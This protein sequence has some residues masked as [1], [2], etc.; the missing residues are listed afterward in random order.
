MQHLKEIQTLK[1]ETA[2]AIRNAISLT[3][4]ITGGP[5]LPMHRASTMEAYTIAVERAI[6]HMKA[7]LAEP[8]DLDQLARVASISRFHLVRVFDELTGTTPHHF[9]ACLRMQ[10]AKDLLLAP[11]AS[12]TEVCLEVGYTSLGTFSTTFST[13]VGFSPQEFRVMTKRLTV[14]QFA[15][16][17]RR[18]L[19]ADRR[20]CEP[21]IDG[22][23][24]GPP[25][26]RGFIFVGSFTHGVPQGAPLSGNVMLKPGAFC[27]KR[28]MIPEFHLLAVLIPFTAKWS[29]MAANLPVR[30]VAGL[31][32]QNQDPAKPLRPQLRLRP[33]RPTDPPIVLALPPL[34]R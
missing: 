18:F 21:R 25:K 11:G 24:E 34:L 31:R 13:L 3:C 8:L 2:T 12:I 27:I 23:V 15:V 4:S 22:V 30:L 16:A 20:I 14:R 10:R 33:V 26:S 6:C 9:L 29:T 7:H 5:P 19:T 17:I 1:S 32:V 28:P